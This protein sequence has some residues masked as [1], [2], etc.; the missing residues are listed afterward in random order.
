[1]PLRDA[2]RQVLRPSSVVATVLL[3]LAGVLAVQGDLAT[4]PIVRLEVETG[5]PKPLPPEAVTAQSEAPVFSIYRVRPGDSLS[6]VARLHGVTLAA[7]LRVNPLRP[8]YELRAGDVLGI[9]DLPRPPTGLDPGSR[10]AVADMLTR[11]AYAY[12]VPSDLLSAVAWRESSWRQSAVSAKGA[13]GIGQ[14]LPTT[15]EWVSA[16]LIGEPLDPLEVEDNVRLSARYLRWLLDRYTGD[17]AAALA[18]YHQGPES[19]DTE[20]WLTSSETY[21]ADVLRLRHEFA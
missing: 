11:W 6:E 21:V 2:F 15:A 20:G 4:R 7:L 13:V 1:M 19:L 12:A 16:R 10:Q 3:V 17:V 14:V 18:A 5:G 9:P 8:P